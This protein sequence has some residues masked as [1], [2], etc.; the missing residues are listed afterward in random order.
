[1]K[2]Y[3]VLLL[4]VIGLN[5]SG[6]N[7][8]LF[9]HYMFNPSYYNPGW[10]GDVKS[11]FATFQHRTQ[12]AGYTTTFD[13]NGG[14]PTSQLMSFAIPVNGKISTAGINFVHDE[15][16][17]EST[18]KIQLGAAY[19]INLNKGELSFGLMGGLVSRT[20]RFDELRFENPSDPLNIGTRESQTKPDIAAGVFYNN[21]DGFF[22]GVGID[23]LL[24]P[25]LIQIDAGST[26][27]SG[28]LAP[29][30]YFHGGKRMDLSRD[31]ELV[32]TFLVKTDFD[33]YSLDISGVLNYKATM[34]GGL[35]YRKAES[36]VLLLG[37]NFLENKAL[38]VGYSFDYVVQNQEAKRPTSHEI[39]IRYEIPSLIL[40]GRKAVKTPRFSF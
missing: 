30:Y 22:G 10:L 38:K 40:G 23:H 5:A 24:S 17:I 9:S 29:V 28:K 33:G 37:Y 31:L 7:D 13:G 18:I 2:K 20:L 11:S 36:A 8:P 6:Q 14:A 25:S 12:W 27:V 34:W 32:P 26:Q 4:F 21:V 15:V 35:S 39:F 3:F 1:M 16:G 19:T